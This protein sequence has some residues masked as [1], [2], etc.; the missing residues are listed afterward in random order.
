MRDLHSGP[1]STS[2]VSVNSSNQPKQEVVFGK[3]ASNQKPSVPKTSDNNATG[4]PK[5][6]QVHME[7]YIYL[8]PYLI[9]ISMENSFFFILL[10]AQYE[11]SVD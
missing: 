3:P 11:I 1:K 7:I 5:K 4:T 2:N 9:K 8:L 10:F 6:P